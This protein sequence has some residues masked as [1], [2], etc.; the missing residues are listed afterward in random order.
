[1]WKIKT[2]F[3]FLNFFLLIVCSDRILRASF[4]FFLFGV[5]TKCK[6]LGR[7]LHGLFLLSFWKTPQNFLL[8]GTVLTY[9]HEIRHIYEFYTCVFLFFL[10]QDA[11]Y[12]IIDIFFFN[13]SLYLPKVF[14]FLVSM[15]R[16]P[17][18]TLHPYPPNLLFTSL[19]LKL[20]KKYKIKDI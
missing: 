13:D 17:S 15:L 20:Q 9:E 5:F 16:T 18:S 10:I 1:M 12:S 19:N 14:F 7:K 3:F 8:N 6:I 11:H 2:K 4:F